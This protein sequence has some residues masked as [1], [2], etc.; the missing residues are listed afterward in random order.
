V[1]GYDYYGT[2]RTLDQTIVQV[3]KKLADLG[4]DPKQIATVHAVGYRWENGP[5]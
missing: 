5:K 1:W 4:A 2:T 3:R